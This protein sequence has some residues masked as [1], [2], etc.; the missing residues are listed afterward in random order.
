MMQHTLQN[1]I[2]I[3]Q[4]YINTMVDRGLTICY[5]DPKAA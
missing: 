4:N 1:Y 5:T 3:A 2:N